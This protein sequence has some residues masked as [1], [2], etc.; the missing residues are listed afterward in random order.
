M[1]RGS[2]SLIAALTATAALVV[3][4]ALPATAAVD[5]PGLWYVDAFHLPDAWAAGYT[6][7]GVTVAIIDSQ[8]HPDI[9]TLAHADVTVREPSFCADDDGAAYPATTDSL[10][11][12]HGTNT[13]SLIVGDGSGS[14]G[15]AGVYGAAPGAKLL[16]YT[17]VITP[18]TVSGLQFDGQCRPV[19][20][21]TSITTIEAVNAAIDDGADI[22]SISLALEADQDWI[23]T[24]LRAA[25]E[26]VVI[27]AGLPDKPGSQSDGFARY[28]SVVA[29]QA[30]GA[31]GAALAT[32]GVP[33]SFEKVTVANAGLGILTQG[34]GSDTPAAER[35]W[36]DQALGDGTSYATPLTA[37][38]LAVVKQKYPKATGNQLIQTLIHNTGAGNP[39]L[40]HDNTYGYGT[41]SLTTMLTVDPT[42]YPDVNPLILD[43]PDAVPAA[44]E[45]AQASAAP[46]ASESPST[47]P[48]ASDDDTTGLAVP[49][50]IGIVVVGA[51]VLAGLVVL[52]VL[53]VRRRP[54]TSPPANSQT[55]TGA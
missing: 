52:I 2:V 9:P 15:A 20:D 44:A 46:S 18:P 10:T 39:D 7:E 11:A 1:R 42:T 50:I 21:P 40:I 13:A 29:V 37:G 14:D 25:R 43:D 12:K 22:I 35:N 48:V 4:P 16:Y 51:L 19:D 26:G 34:S 49:V 47:A 3:A 38:F 17:G 8:F 6:G 55:Q 23:P 32:D 36:T 30:I 33:N 28:N 27:V 41:A 54:S 5:G 24:I 45:F 31:D 53:L